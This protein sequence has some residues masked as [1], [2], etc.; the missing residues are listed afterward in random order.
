MDA[1]I[2]AI[3]QIAAG[4]SDVSDKDSQVSKEVQAWDM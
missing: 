2:D 4:K 1:L 3:R